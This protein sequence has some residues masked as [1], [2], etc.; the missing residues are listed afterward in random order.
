MPAGGRVAGVVE[1]DDAEVGALVLRLGDEAAVH[2]GVAARLEDEQPPDVVEV[3]G[4]VAALV[5][6]RPALERLDA[7]GDD[8][9]R[10]A[11][12]VVVDR[13]DQRPVKFGGRFS[14]NAATPS[15]KSS[16]FV[17]AVCSSASSASC[18]SSVAFAAWSNRR[19]DIPIPRVGRGGVVG[20]ELGGPGGQRVGLDDLVHQPPG[21]A[22]AAVS[23]RFED[24][25]V[26]ARDAPSSRAMKYEPPG[27][28]D[29]P[30]PDETGHEARA[31]GGEPVVAD[32]RQREPRAGGRPVDRGDHGLL[33]RADRPHVR[34][35]GRLEMLADVVVEVAELVQVLAGAEA[36]ARAR[37]HDRAHVLRR[38]PPRARHAAQRA[39]RS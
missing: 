13:R 7:A 23:L 26:K 17:A 19:F 1:E 28:G 33:E 24:I 6:D 31:V 35:V 11:A 14:R 37:D 29:E 4:G 10:L 38:R 25:Q 18:S 3:L 21:M 9:E 2:V 32:A 39:S 12:G 15:R 30:D 27:V 5:E 34:V 22:S 36:A 8:A 20:G 16:V